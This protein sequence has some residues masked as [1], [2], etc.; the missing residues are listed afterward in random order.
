MSSFQKKHCVTYSV[1]I[2]APTGGARSDLQ[3]TS[4]KNDF[5][6]NRDAAGGR[7]RSQARRGDL[8]SG[9]SEIS[10]FGVPVPV[11]NYSVLTASSKLKNSENFQKW[12]AFLAFQA[13]ADVRVGGVGASRNSHSEAPDLDKCL[14][15]SN[16]VHAATNIVQGRSMQNISCESIGCSNACGVL[17]DY[18]AHLQEKV[19]HGIFLGPKHCQ[20]CLDKRALYGTVAANTVAHT[21]LPSAHAAG[22]SWLA[23]GPP[24]SET[25]APHSS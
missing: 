23:N 10:T 22:V 9:A 21:M 2:S 7:F 24:S 12:R 6:R 5:S 3:Y 15:F 4:S 16:G 17:S 20:Q 8:F 13:Q 18:P 14:P 11:L 25:A 19:A 1:G